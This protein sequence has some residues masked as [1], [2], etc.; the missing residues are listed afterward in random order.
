MKNKVG[1]AGVCFIVAMISFFFTGKMNVIAA[2][3]TSVN[4]TSMLYV[5]GYEVTNETIIPGKDFTLTIKLGNFSKGVDAKNV[6]VSVNNPDG[7]TPEYGTVSQTYVETVSAGEEVE[8]AFKYNS[9]TTIQA[10]VLN[11]NVN[12][13]DGLTYNT[14]QL[15]IPV[16]RI[17]DFD[18]DDVTLPVIYEENKTEY[19]SAKIVNL[20]N[21]GVSNV[22][23]VVRCNGEDIASTNIGTMS[24]GK[25]KTQ[26]VSVTFEKAG[27]YSLE[28]VLTYVDGEGNNKE[29][30]IASESVKVIES[31]QQS[32]EQ[33]ITSEQVEQIVQQSVPQ[34]ESQTQR[35]IV[36]CVS[37]ILLIAVCCII[38]LLL[39]KRK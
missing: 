25:T 34:K 15:R 8:V 17:T 7:V 28:L 18:V 5:T 19:V 2:E 13:S 36:I 27:A 24:A 38:L 3:N 6:F 33:S 16:G 22:T 32:D 26:S 39:Q 10:D 31:M 37:G 30:T 1:R 21:A 29:Y 11:F 9:W 20:D 12:I 23:M 35:I 4:N 14:A